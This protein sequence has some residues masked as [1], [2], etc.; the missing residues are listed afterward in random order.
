MPANASITLNGGDLNLKTPSSSSDD[1]SDIVWFYGNGN[2]KMR[3][4]TTNTYTTN[5]GPN[6]RLYKSDGTS[7]YS[8]KLVAGHNV[9]S[10]SQPAYVNNDGIASAVTTV[11]TAYGGT[12]NT[13]Y[14]ATRLLYTNTATKFATGSLV[15]DG[16]YIAMTGTSKNWNQ[17]HESL[18]R[19]TS[20]N[21]WAPAL[22]IKSD[23]GYW[24]I[25]HYNNASFNDELIFGFLHDD[26]K[27]GATNASNRLRTTV[28]LIPSTAAGSIR[29]AIVTA[30]YTRSNA[31][32]GTAAVGGTK[33]P[34]YINAQGVATECGTLVNYAFK[35]QTEYN[36]ITTPDA[37]TIYFIYE[38][39]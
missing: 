14:T 8:G 38:S 37:D 13:S 29:R 33:K 1:S 22:S 18:I 35:T 27:Y 16:T 15:S 36:G 26:D 11:G 5:T 31:T 10:T 39:V 19:Q 12:G 30:P 6:Y 24:A 9:G 3:I 17:S 32:D 7:L 34:I 25:G 21:A 2:E 23:V 20:K 28:S 4:W